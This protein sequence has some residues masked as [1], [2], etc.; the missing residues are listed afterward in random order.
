MGW[1]VLG[2]EGVKFEVKGAWRAGVQA[3][4]WG[5]RGVEGVKVWV[6]RGGGLVE[7]RGSRFGRGLWRGEVQ[8]FG[9]GR[10]CRGVEGGKVWGPWGGMQGVELVKVW[11][12]AGGGVH[13]RWSR[14]GVGGCVRGEAAVQGLGWGLPGVE[15][16]KVWS[17]GC[18][19]KRGLMRKGSM[20]ADQVPRAPCPPSDFSELYMYVRCILSRR[21][22]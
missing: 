22:C 13:G 9:M 6:G 16:A 1:G 19:E 8:G 10:G 2:G 14:F 18:V 3:S 21:R 15:G 20:Y 4:G 7:W 12:G 11:G 5:V 17:G